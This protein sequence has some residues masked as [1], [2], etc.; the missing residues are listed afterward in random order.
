MCALVQLWV[1]DTKLL[2]LQLDIEPARCGSPP[3]EVTQ[4]VVELFR[5]CDGMHEV[6]F[7]A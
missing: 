7:T 4:G 6:G 1:D 2:L 3:I 5:W